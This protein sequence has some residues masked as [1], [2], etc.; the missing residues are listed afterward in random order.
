MSLE[1][2]NGSLTVNS[3]PSF[4]HTPYINDLNEALSYSYCVIFADDTNI[5]VKNNNYSELYKDMSKKL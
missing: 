2:L 5:F 4:I 3:R 1:V